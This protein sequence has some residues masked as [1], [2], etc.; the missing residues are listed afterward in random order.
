MILCPNCKKPLDEKH[1]S[2]FIQLKSKVKYTHCPK[3]ETVFKANQLIVLAGKEELKT[4]ISIVYKEILINL[5]AIHSARN[6][7]LVLK[8]KFKPLLDILE[9]R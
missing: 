8:N 1:L 7:P 6:P 9:K 4:A 5:D 2:S 3:C